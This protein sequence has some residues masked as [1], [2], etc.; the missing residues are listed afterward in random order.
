MAIPLYSWKKEIF[1]NEETRDHLDFIFMLLELWEQRN[2]RLRWNDEHWE[3]K[4]HVSINWGAGKTITAAAWS[5]YINPADA[6]H[7][8]MLCGFAFALT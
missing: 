3:K 8:P 7:F 1:R 6:K 4:V 5:V 2:N